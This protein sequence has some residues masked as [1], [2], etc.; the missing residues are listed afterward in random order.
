MEQ[1][2]TDRVTFAVKTCGK[3]GIHYG[4]PS[5]FMDHRK[6]DGATWYCP[7]G[8]PWVVAK[9]KVQ[10]LEEQ[11]AQE[12]KRRE[13]AVDRANRQRERAIAAERTTIAY[14]GHLTRVKKRIGN[15]ACP[16]CNRH[17]KN[18]EHHMKSKHPTYSA[19]E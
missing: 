2:F 14:R 1:V 17:F 6:I 11:V 16:C 19:E 10:E 9:T 8:H 12:S 4:V 7:N 18:V 15:G 5:D 13:E 3:C